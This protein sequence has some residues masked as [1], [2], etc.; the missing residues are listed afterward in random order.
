VDIVIVV[1]AS[2]SPVRKRPAT[3]NGVTPVG[4]AAARTATL[5]T[6]GGKR[7]RRARTSA[8]AGMAISLSKISGS[9]ISV[10]LP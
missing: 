7:T 8:S 6:I 3:R 9:P 2:P 4:Q 10:V 5:V 1:D